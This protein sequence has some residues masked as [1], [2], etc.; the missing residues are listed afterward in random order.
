MSAVT[1]DQIICEYPDQLREDQW[2]LVLAERKRLGRILSADDVRSV[3]ASQHSHDDA[4]TV[5]L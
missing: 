4:R 3:I 5:G 1:A 2:A